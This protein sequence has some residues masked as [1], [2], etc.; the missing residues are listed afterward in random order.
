[1]RNFHF[2][3]LTLPGLIDPAIAIAASH[4]GAIGVLDLTYA[5][6]EHTALAAMA[7]LVRYAKGSCG[8]KLDACSPRLIESILPQLPEQIQFVILTPADAD[9]STP[10][11]HALRGRKLTVLLETISIDEARLGEQ[12]LVDGLIAKGHESGGRIGEETTFILLQRLL[13]HTSLPIWAQGGIGL[14]SAAACYVAGAAGI[15]LDAQL[16]LTRESPVPEV[17]HAVIARMDGSETIGLS[18]EPGEA[19]RVYARPHHSVID[20]LPESIADTSTAWQAA[21]RARIG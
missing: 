21:V 4:A 8:L 14:H 17:A 18:G 5:T 6:D 3:A 2:A 10:Y 1:M 11:V 20:E 19:F 13:A 16:L 15:V 7:K 12:L 9:R